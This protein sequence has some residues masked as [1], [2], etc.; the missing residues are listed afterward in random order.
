MVIIPYKSKVISKFKQDE[1]EAD[2]V[3]YEITEE[4]MEEILKDQTNIESEMHRFIF[5]QEWGNFEMVIDNI[6]SGRIIQ[7]GII[8]GKYILRYYIV[9]RGLNELLKMI[10]MQEDF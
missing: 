5:Y 8:G 2:I 7:G 4:D 9:E 10:S 6:S 1:I 3:N